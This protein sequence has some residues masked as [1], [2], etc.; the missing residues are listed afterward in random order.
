MSMKD[1]A[2][3]VGLRS[4]SMSMYPPTLFGA[5]TCVGIIGV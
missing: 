3:V 4:E 2:P 1:M 5:L